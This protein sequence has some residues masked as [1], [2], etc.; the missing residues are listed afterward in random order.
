MFLE[1]KEEI[2]CKFEFSSFER[3]ELC[4]LTPVPDDDSG[5]KNV[6]GFI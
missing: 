5:N 1:F 4:L 6:F 2:F 3:K